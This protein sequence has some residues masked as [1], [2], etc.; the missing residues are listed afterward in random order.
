MKQSILIVED[1]RDVRIS[2]KM[3]LEG[4]GYEVAEAENGKEAIEAVSD[5]GLS[6]VLLDQVAGHQWVRRVQGNP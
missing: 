2:L 3:L 6:L 4:E 5:P 1:D